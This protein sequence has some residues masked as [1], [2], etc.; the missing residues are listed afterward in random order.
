MWFLKKPIWWV[1][2]SRVN[3]VK[4]GPKFTEHFLFNAENLLFFFRYLYPFRRYSRL[5]SEVRQNRA[6]FSMFFAPPPNF[7]GGRPP[8]FFETGIIKLNM[9]PTGLTLSFY[10]SLK[11]SRYSNI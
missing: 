1:S 10:D 3:A 11:L 7:F 4:S 8:I 2:I 9:L 5:K 6:K